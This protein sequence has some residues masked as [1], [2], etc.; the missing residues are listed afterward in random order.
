VILTQYN[1]LVSR[2]VIFLFLVV[3]LVGTGTLAFILMDGA[4]TERLATTPQADERSLEPINGARANAADAG[5]DA[6]QEG[7]AEHDRTKRDAAVTNLLKGTVRSRDGS[8]LE[9]AKVVALDDSDHETGVAT[10]AEGG[11]SLPLGSSSY[12]IS[13][14]HEGYLPV[15][16][17]GVYAVEF[18][19]FREIV[20]DFKLTPA[21]TLSGRVFDGRGMPV[22]G[23]RV[24]V[25]PAHHFLLEASDAGNTVITDAAGRYMFPGLRAGVTDVGVRAR[26]F[27][28]SIQR[29]FRVPSSGANEL[30]F[31]LKRG[32]AIEVRILGGQPNEPVSL[33]ASDAWPAAGVL[34]PG[35]FD[36]LNDALV[37]REFVD[38]VATRV[39]TKTDADGRATVAL[40]GFG[41]GPVDIE[42]LQFERSHG[43]A[44]GSRG[45]PVEISMRRVVQVL[46]DAR[47]ASTGAQLEP[48]VRIEPMARWLMLYWTTV[49]DLYV[50]M[51]L[52]GKWRVFLDL[53]G[54]ESVELTLPEYETEKD[55]AFSARLNV[56]M[57]P[58]TAAATGTFLLESSPPFDGRI[59]VVGRDA[60]GVIQWVKH[61][62]ETDNDKRFVVAGVPEGTFDIAVLAEGKIPTHVPRV[63]VRKGIRPVYRVVFTDGGGIELTV[64]G[65]GGNLLEKV[66]IQLHNH[67]GTQ[68]DVQI[69]SEVSVGRALVSVNYIPSVAHVMSDSG[70]APG[71]YT[72]RALK[73]GYQPSQ[74]S[75]AIAGTETA[76]VTLTL[77]KR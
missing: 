45:S 6:V 43:E 41:N 40:V 65:K 24:Y 76:R 27:R 75:F 72:L 55:G 62:T 1:R 2:G 60:A 71:R 42:A 19:D 35:G 52:D 16:L 63:V 59:A 29:D 68:I 49:I 51:S 20:R 13:V 46:V 38:L 14:V 28:P 69:Y 77:Q 31:T 18:L 9:G 26:G 8:P 53:E 5:S 39:D 17:T 15:M 70:L 21:A 74:A 54:Y 37:G 25:I 30:D 73:E 67:A 23:A 57:T 48:T 66:H 33:F 56:A 22:I 7:A 3:A 50:P 44:L 64:T 4:A 10:G 47:D 34:P 11:Y 61:P 36:V 58:V 12:Q 32:R